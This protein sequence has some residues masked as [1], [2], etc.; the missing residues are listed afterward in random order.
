MRLF[1][2]LLALCVAAALYLVVMQ[3]D[4]LLSVAGG[5]EAE[6]PASE[7]A[8]EAPRSVEEDGTG[9]GATRV[10][11][12]MAIDSEA[13][14]VDSAVITRGRTE[15]ARQVTVRAETPGQIVSEPL[16]KGAFVEAGQMLC[17]IDAG[18]RE[19]QLAQA[20][21]QL[22]SAR[23]GLPESLAR[24][25]E[26]EAAL[27]EAEI[28]DRAASQLSEG[29]YA[30]ETRVA[31]TKAAVSSARA[32]VQAAQSGVEGAKSQVQTAEAA[33]ATAQKDI[34]RLTITAP[35][36]GL[37]ESDSA[38]LG[39]LLQSGSDCATILQLDPIKLVGFVPETEVSRVKV[40]AKAGARLA[41][42]EEVTGEVTFLSRSAD[43]QTR[44]FRVEVQ[45]PNADLEIRD[46]QTAEI[47]ISA[48]GAKAHLL[49]QSSL[50][51]DDGGALG[52]RWVD[53][54]NTARFAPVTVLRDTVDGIWVTG[55]PETARVI[56]R[57]QEYVVEGVPVKVTLEE[58]TQ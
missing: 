50:T 29:G 28:N 14:E 41:T 6:A 55:L 33:V 45:V 32:A 8:P 43:A 7:T 56:T 11:S 17:V 37:L 52:V 51:L 40:G 44:T 27:E 25:A 4:V 42:G 16:R 30:S 39:V 47:V 46:G 18:T 34:D 12:V 5:G 15:A 10:V 57:G 54:E 3:R 9:A 36:S 49:P 1:S 13:R 58:L 22:A 48:A 26:A 24:V 2:I 35:F 53:E 31:A 21:A 38:E 20:E 19:T 23:A